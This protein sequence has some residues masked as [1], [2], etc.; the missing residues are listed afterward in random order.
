MYTIEIKKP[1]SLLAFNWA[2]GMSGNCLLRL[3]VVGGL[4]IEIDIEI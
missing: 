1:F 3:L 4:Y 2:V